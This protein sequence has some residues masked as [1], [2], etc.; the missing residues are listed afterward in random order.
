MTFKRNHPMR[1]VRAFSLIELMVA[2]PMA[3]MVLAG[4]MGIATGMMRYSRSMADEQT[5]SSEA[6]LARQFLTASVANL[7]YGWLVDAPLSSP[8]STTGAPAT[9]HCVSSTNLCS[10]GGDTTILPL[11]L[12]LNSTT[13]TDEL[14]ALVP[15][16]P[17]AEA[18]QIQELS[19]APY[20]S[21]SVCSTFTY[22]QSFTVKGTNNSQWVANDLVL[23]SKRGHVSV[24]TVT[25]T[26]AIG[27]DPAVARTLHID[28]GDKLYLDD[29]GRLPDDDGGCNVMN[30]LLSARIFR[31]QRIAI[32]QTTMADVDGNGTI[33]SLSLTTMK[34]AS[35]AATAQAVLTNV[36]DFQAQI[37]IVKFPQT[38][39]PPSTSVTSCDCN[40][41]A[42]LSGATF[43]S[44]ACT[45]STSGRLN[46]DAS[47]ADVYRILGLR[48][49]VV[50]QGTL[51]VRQAN[52][53]T[54]GLFDN[55]ST[56]IATDM[57][58]HRST[59][60]YVGLPNAQVQ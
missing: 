36:E 48:L 44:P 24:A 27:T 10:G 8:T 30:S 6:S 41:T 55:S 37:E 12:S 51:D 4:A 60:L 32:T 38:A 19:N 13:G 18:V 57:R 58:R 39:V 35:P 52:R 33:K 11:D 40:T 53:N 9:G 29:G 42:C 31:I 59:T 17:Q 45:C 23:V 7:G 20:L 43:T 28:M 54:K 5:L 21:G 3:L 1:G 25:Q 15:R 47:V 34:K 56:T 26:F 2:S 14:R 22:E 50:M 46:V 49:G 16:D